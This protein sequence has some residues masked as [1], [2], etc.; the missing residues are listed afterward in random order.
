[1]VSLVEIISNKGYNIFIEFFYVNAGYSDNI[2]TFPY[3]C[4]FLLKRYLKL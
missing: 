3:F 4:T 2:Y 1:M